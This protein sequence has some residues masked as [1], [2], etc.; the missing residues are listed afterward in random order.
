MRVKGE[1]NDEKK[2]RESFSQ[3]ENL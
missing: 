2:E 1:K 3:F